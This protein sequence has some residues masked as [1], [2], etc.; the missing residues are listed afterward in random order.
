MLDFGKVIDMLFAVGQIQSVEDARGTLAVKNH[1]HIVAHQPTA[2]A[3][4]VGGEMTA[5]R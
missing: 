5:A 2:Q 3:Q 4:R 1:V